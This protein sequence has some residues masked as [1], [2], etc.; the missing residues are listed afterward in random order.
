MSNIVRSF[1]GKKFIELRNVSTNTNIC[2]DWIRKNLDR[3]MDEK[4]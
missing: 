3:P 1:I 4:T 2:K